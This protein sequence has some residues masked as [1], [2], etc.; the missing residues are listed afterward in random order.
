MDGE[1]RIRSLG[2]LRRRICS[3]PPLPRASAAERRHRS[4]PRAAPEDRR[5]IHS[6]EAHWRGIRFPPPLLTSL[7]LRTAIAPPRIAD[8]E[9]CRR[10]IPVP[11]PRSGNDGSALPRL[12]DAGSA[13]SRCCCPSPVQ[14]LDPPSLHRRPLHP[15]HHHPTRPTPASRIHQQGGWVTRPGGPSLPVGRC[16]G[17]GTGGGR[18]WWRQLWPATVES[19]GWLAVGMKTDGN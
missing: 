7:T 16:G 11:L 6:P 2:T 5:Q 18:R 1:R 15:R 12:V 8:A 9:S 14:L 10:P 4:L 19:K 17:D 3:P 13:P